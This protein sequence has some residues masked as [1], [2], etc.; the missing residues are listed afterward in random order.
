MSKPSIIVKVADQY[1]NKVI[2]PACRQAKLFAKLAGTKTLTKQAVLTIKE[3]GYDVLLTDIPQLD[4]L[5]G[6]YEPGGAL[7]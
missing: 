2:I 6:L 1:G 4:E 3:L 5:M 7:A